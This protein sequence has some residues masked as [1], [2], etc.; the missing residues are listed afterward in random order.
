MCS[1]CEVHELNSCYRGC[2]RPHVLCPKM[3][4]G[5]STCWISSSVCPPPF[6]GAVTYTVLAASINKRQRVKTSYCVAHHFC[7][8]AD[9]SSPATEFGS[10]LWSLN[11]PG[12]FETRLN[13]QYVVG[14]WRCVSLKVQYMSAFVETDKIQTT[15]NSILYTPVTLI[16][17]FWLHARL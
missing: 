5:M 12:K 4:N 14:I 9:L 6:Q 1:S 15:T 17:F 8:C 7:V 11:Q 13:L 16:Q 3:L 2:F 10:H